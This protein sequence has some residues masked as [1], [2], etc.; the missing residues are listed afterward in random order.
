MESELKKGSTFYFTIPMKVTEKPVV[1]S[2]KKIST[3]VSYF[4][5]NKKI[6]IAEDNIL[7]YKLIEAILD[8]TEAWLVWAKDGVE[9]VEFVSSGQEFDLVLMD[10]RMPNMDG[11]QATQEIRQLKKELPVVA[12][13]ACG[14]GYEKEMA[15]QA[16]FNDYLTKPV[17]AEKLIETI[18]KY[19]HEEKIKVKSKKIKVKR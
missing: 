6:L 19:I 4:L 15:R 5:K 17:N 16:G 12:I 14:M 7:N 10:I 13:T 1:D 9:A 11:F 2:E 18:N 8:K 3:P